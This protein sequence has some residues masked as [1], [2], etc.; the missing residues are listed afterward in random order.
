MADFCKQCSLEIFGEDF[1]ELAGQLTEKQ[2]AKGFV[3][4]CICEG[5]GFTY[6]N[7]EGECVAPDCLKKHGAKTNE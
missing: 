5:C 4:K 7:N 3:A 2:V 1:K 6:V